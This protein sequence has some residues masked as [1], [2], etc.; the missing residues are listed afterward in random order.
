MY[1]ND[2]KIHGTHGFGD[3]IE[4]L[5]HF[6]HCIVGT[7]SPTNHDGAS[8]NGTLGDPM[9]ELVNDKRYTLIHQSVQVRG[10]ARHFCHHANVKK[11]KVFS[12]SRS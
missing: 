3:Q 2:N 11:K 6:I 1:I 8:T 9:F 4:S 10:R 5:H 7:F 12:V